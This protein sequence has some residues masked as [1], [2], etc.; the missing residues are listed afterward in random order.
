M[1]AGTYP[2]YWFAND[3]SGNVNVTSIFN[4]IINKT[5]PPITLSFSPSSTVNQGTET[6]TSGLSC[7]SQLTCNL[8]QG[9]IAVSNPHITTFGVGTYPYTFN[10]TGNTNYT[11]ASVTTN[12]TVQA[13]GGGGNVTTISA[14]VICPENKFGFY[15]PLLPHI[16]KAGCL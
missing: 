11:S 15:N 14:P 12:L 5:V 7:P 16:V 2:Y 13:T 8:F 4:Y 10:T 3:S 9:T 6:T 1:S